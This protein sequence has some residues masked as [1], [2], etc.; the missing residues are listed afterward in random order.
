MIYH[1]VFQRDLRADGMG[2]DDDAPIPA[3]IDDLAGFGPDLLSR[4]VDQS[5]GNPLYS[6]GF[7]IIF[8]V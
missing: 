8:A 5:T 2:S 7:K 1:K 4:A 3:H 6:Q